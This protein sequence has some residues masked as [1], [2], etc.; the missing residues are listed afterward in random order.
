M[1]KDWKTFVL[2]AVAIAVVFYAGWSAR[3][4]CDLV[5]PPSQDSIIR[6]LVDSANFHYGRA[7]VYRVER[8]T[9]EARRLRWENSLEDDGTKRN[10]IGHAI[11]NAGLDTAVR[12]L[13]TRPD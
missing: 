8:D 1:V 13:S 9:A 2:I 7:E 6:A 12:I 10:R 4:G 3:G 5:V 11:R